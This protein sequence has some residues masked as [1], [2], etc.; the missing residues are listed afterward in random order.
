MNFKLTLAYDGT[1][2]CGWQVQAHNQAGAPQ[3]TVQGQLERAVALLEGQ[4]RTVHGAGRTDAGVHAEAQIANVQITRLL[5][6]YKLFGALNGNLPRDLRVIK[7]EEVADDFHA[8]FSATGKTYR[9]RIFNENFTSPFLA[10]Y[11]VTE[12]RAIDVKRM[13]EAAQLFVGTR[14]WTAFSSLH[15]DVKTRVRRVTQM[16][17]EHF[18]HAAAHGRVIE[19]TISA[20]GFLRYMARSIVGTLMEVGRGEIGLEQVAEAIETGNRQLAGATAPARG[21]TLVRVHYEN[22]GERT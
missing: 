18:Y 2:F 19:I 6:S 3:R 13:N 8:R 5:D 22:L 7:V 14:D 21:L 11:A 15:T 20:D 1:D 4:A 9:Y 12:A 17:I 16:Q 10:R